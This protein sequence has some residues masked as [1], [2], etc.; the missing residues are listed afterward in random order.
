MLNTVHRAEQ[1]EDWKSEMQS[2]GRVTKQEHLL[3]YNIKINAAD[4]IP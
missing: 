4:N 2:R 3:E 1:K